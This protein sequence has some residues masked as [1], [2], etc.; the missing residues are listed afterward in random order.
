[1]ISSDSTI[2]QHHDDGRRLG[3]Q[4]LSVWFQF[5]GNGA[6]AGYEDGLVSNSGIY[7]QYVTSGT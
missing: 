6:Q 2:E 5:P 7:I 4:Q 3:T 1:M